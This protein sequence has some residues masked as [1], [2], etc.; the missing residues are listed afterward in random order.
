MSHKIMYVVYDASE[1]GK[2]SI[3]QKCEKKSSQSKKKFFV[4]KKKIRVFKKDFEMPKK[5]F[6]MPKEIICDAEK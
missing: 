6:E 5:G 2:C 4:G 3:T 1:L